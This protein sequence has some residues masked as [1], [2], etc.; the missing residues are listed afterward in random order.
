M[1]TDR[2]LNDLSIVI[3]ALNE[4]RNL[5]DLLPQ[6]KSV[7]ASLNLRYEIVVVDE[8]ANNQTQEVVNR[9]G[10]ILLS[11][12]IHGYA[13]ALLAGLNY[14]SSQFIATLDADLSHPPEFLRQM[15]IN[16]HS[17]DVIIAS[18][19]IP[20][21]H[22]SM[23][24]FRYVLSRILN[25]LFSRG[26]DLGVRD[27]SS[28]MRLYNSC[29]LDLRAIE[30]EDFDI[31][32]ELL[33]KALVK[34]YTVIEIPFTYQPRRYGSSQARVLCFGL[35]YIKTFVRIWKLRNSI[36]SADYDYRAYD[37]LVVIQR[38][39]Q[40]KR[41][42]YIVE[43]IPDRVRCIDIGCG[44]SRI[45]ERLPPGSVALDILMRK[46]RFARRFLPRLIQ[47]SAVSLPIGNNCFPCVV[48]SQVIEHIDSKSTLVELDR[49]LEPGGML[50]LGTPDYGKW[51][52]KVIEWFYGK[53]LPQS[54]ADEHVTHYTYHELIQEFVEKRGYTLIATRYIMQG[55]L[56]FAF[57]KP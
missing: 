42:Q 5:A 3:P 54:Y 9:N 27:M 29:A 53:L 38:Y 37:S 30:S 44:S 22:A 34:G 16:R 36:V 48:C 24:V 26:L 50:V 35:A 43:L 17:A 31:L 13:A 33:V 23:P 2:Y 55:E 18:R 40:R 39:W 12:R 19:Y 10:A 20:E 21:G 11:P 32:Q 46:L 4:A 15:W 57:R 49:I 51:Q 6:I 56:I 7:L 52:W 41:Y 28:G 14:A 1:S 45:L 25:M 47:G 8:L